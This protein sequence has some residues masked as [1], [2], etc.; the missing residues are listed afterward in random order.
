MSNSQSNTEEMMAQLAL[1]PQSIAQTYRMPKQVQKGL[2]KFYQEFPKATKAE[3]WHV[4]PIGAFRDPN[5]RTARVNIQYRLVLRIPFDGDH[6]WYL[7]WVDNHDEAMAWAE[8]KVVGRPPGAGGV[9]SKGR[10]RPGLYGKQDLRSRPTG[11]VQPP[12][13]DERIQG[14]HPEVR[15]RDGKRLP[16]RGPHR[17]GLSAGENTK[18]SDLGHRADL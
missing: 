18:G 14:Y 5:L 3:T 15:L 10:P 17:S 8:N 1:T 16:P 13:A 12:G 7:L 9:H 11:A 2:A 6:T 4:E